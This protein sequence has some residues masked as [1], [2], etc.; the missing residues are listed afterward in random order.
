MV[1]T[2]EQQDTEG[3]NESEPS[4]SH[5]T[6]QFRTKAREFRAYALYL[7]S[8]QMDRWKLT[9]TRIAIY[10]ALGVGALAVASAVLVFG[11]GLLLL[12]LAGL[13]GRLV[14][15]FWLGATIVGFLVLTVPFVAGW[16]TFRTVDRRIVAALRAKYSAI[17]Q[18]QKS[19]FGRDIREAADAR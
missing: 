7:A 16:I 11:T 13:V 17:R 12:G 1:T 4:I 14:E 19:A 15:S 3:G 8:L 6:A 18:K 9:S 2:T 5:L 10:A